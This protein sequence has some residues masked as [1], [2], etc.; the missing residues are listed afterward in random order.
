M[1]IPTR[2]ALSIA[3]ATAVLLSV[4]S[5]SGNPAEAGGGQ[6]PGGTAHQNAHH[7]TGET[8]Q[9]RH[10][11]SQAKAATA[12]YRSPQ[13]AASDGYAV[14]PAPAPLHE[15]IRAEDGHAAMGVHH[16]KAANLD[17]TLDAEAPEVLVYEPTEN[18]RPRL[19]ALE[20]VVFEDAWKAEHGESTPRLFGRDLTY[21]GAG[22]RYELPPFYQ[23]HAWVW[24]H[25]PDGLFA[26]H[27]PRVSCPGSPAVESPSGGAHDFGPHY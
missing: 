8:T 26:D 5:C 21:V 4:A 14:P 16:I 24:K 1:S 13:M 23:I 9:V 20:Y 11:L 18:G 19:V 15:C 3:A 22:N 12:V 7:P 25:N 27:N 17:A 6:S 2:N 10:A